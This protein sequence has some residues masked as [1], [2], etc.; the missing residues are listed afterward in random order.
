[1]Y[2]VSRAVISGKS[3]VFGVARP[4]P[5]PGSTQDLLCDPEPLTSPLWASI[6]SSANRGVT[7]SPERPGL[8][9]GVLGGQGRGLTDEEQGEDEGELVDGMA[10]DILHHGPRDEGLVA[11]IRLPQ[12]QGL[13]GRLSG[14]RQ[15]GERV[16]DEVHPEH[17]HGLQGGVLGTVGETVVMNTS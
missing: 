10:Q 12:E 11:A 15:G 6:T 14:Q 3:P 2:T 7:G 17:L 1:M 13:G 16:H 5:G 9:H 4:G 8:G